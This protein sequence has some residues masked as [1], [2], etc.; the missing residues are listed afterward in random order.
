MTPEEQAFTTAVAATVAEIERAT[1]A[2]II[3]V[4][5]GTS[6]GYPDVPLLA[7]IGAGLVGLIVLLFLPFDFAPWSV[8]AVVAGLGI[9]G[10]AAGGRFEELTRRLTSVARR[11]AQVTQA[12]A[13]AFHREA[14]AGTRNRTGVLLYAS[15]LERLL[16]I[17]P[18]SG[19]TRA[20]APGELYG[21]MG[22]E[23]TPLPPSTEGF[24]A[25]VRTLGVLLAARLPATH[26]NPNELPDEPRFL[27]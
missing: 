9:A 6:G 1:D 10:G 24:V 26:D 20:I 4:H 27:P 13:A 23:V 2:E 19:V 7:G 16:V 11:R 14:V 5:A 21:V 8:P 17:I 25:A 15:R 3:V 18:D 12:A 22:G